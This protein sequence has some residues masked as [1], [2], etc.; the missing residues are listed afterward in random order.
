MTLTFE[1]LLEHHLV[2]ISSLGEALSSLKLRKLE[3]RV[4]WELSGDTVCFAHHFVVK[5]CN[6]YCNDGIIC[7]YTCEDFNQGFLYQ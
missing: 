4:I 5:H 2:D 7:I 1:S 3:K 6:A